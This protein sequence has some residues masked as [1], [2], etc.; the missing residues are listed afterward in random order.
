MKER[1]L[2]DAEQRRLERFET[3]SADLESQGYTRTNLDISIVGANIVSVALLIALLV[4]VLPLFNI[5]HP[6]SE[7]FLPMWE[8]LVCLAA[9]IALIAVHEF[10]HG[11]TWSRFTPHGFKDVEFGIMRDSLTPYCACLVPLGKTPYL[12]GALMPLLILGIIP[13]I[14]GLFAGWAPLVYL[15]LFMVLAATGDMMIAQ[16][17]LAYRSTS[18]DM[19]LFDHP[20]EA[21]SVVFER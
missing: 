13:L 4:V 1:S 17:L 11:F 7:L 15:A 16:K 8:F 10:I 12:T 6:E 3:T 18:S 14:V 2:T 9:C 5:M 20:T 21:G 19:L